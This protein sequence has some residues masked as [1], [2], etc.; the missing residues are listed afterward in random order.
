MKEMNKSLLLGVGLIGDVVQL[1][2]TLQTDDA[3]H[4]IVGI[5][6][7]CPIFVSRPYLWIYFL[8]LDQIASNCVWFSIDYYL[9][10]CVSENNRSDEPF[11]W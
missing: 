4:L 3:I 9:L 1:C 10:I 6:Q 5:R 8:Y 7:N 11:Y 2:D